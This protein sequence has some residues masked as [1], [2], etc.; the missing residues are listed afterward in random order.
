MGYAVTMFVFIRSVGQTVGVAIG[1]A[2]FQNA[3]RKKLLTYPLLADRAAEFA[4][5]ASSLVQVVKAMA[6]G[7]EKAQ[8][9]ES[10]VY[11]LRT[12]WIVMAA[13]A[14][15]AMIGSMLG[16]RALPLDRVLETEHGY[17]ARSEVKDME[18]MTT[19]GQ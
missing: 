8:L 4:R 3:M 2:I 7:P 1:G 5:E 10:Y 16:T 15:T 18:K 9:L 12:V 13:L 6:D 11:A 17:K 14:G 19:E